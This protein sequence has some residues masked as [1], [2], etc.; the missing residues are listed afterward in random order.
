MMSLRKQ[1]VSIIIVVKDTDSLY[2][3]EKYWFALVDNGFLGIYLGLGKMITVIR[4]FFML[5]PGS[6]DK[7]L[8]SDC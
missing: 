6:E 5:G 8:F 4:I 7:V 1:M 3:H 2:I